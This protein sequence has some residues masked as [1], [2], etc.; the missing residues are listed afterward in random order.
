MDLN[1]HKVDQLLRRVTCVP[2]AS[3][4]VERILMVH[5]FLHACARPFHFLDVKRETNRKFNHCV[6]FLQS[7]IV[8]QPFNNF[9]SDL[10]RLVMGRQDLRDMLFELVAGQIFIFGQKS[11]D[12]AE[13]SRIYVAFL[14]EVQNLDQ[15]EVPCPVSFI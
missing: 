14:S 2:P 1:A 5:D 11:L 8:T 9:L 4:G 12:L 6:T 10:I 13:V 3:S 7:V 15:G